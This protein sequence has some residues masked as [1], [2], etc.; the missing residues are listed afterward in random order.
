MFDISEFFCSRNT[1][2]EV[3]RSERV[4]TIRCPCSDTE[5]NAGTVTH[6]QESSIF[7]DWTPATFLRLMETGLASSFVES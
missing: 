4:F 3:K 5:I 7:N 2:T 6:L 1:D